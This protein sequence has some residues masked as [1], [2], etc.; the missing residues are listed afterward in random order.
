MDWNAFA[1]SGWVALPPTIS[2]LGAWWQGMRV[3]RATKDER[4]AARKEREVLTAEVKRLN[5]RIAVLTG[6][7]RSTP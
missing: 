7:D 2:A 1:N 6:E 5:A 4:E 3:H